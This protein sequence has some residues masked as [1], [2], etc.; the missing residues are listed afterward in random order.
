M[1]PLPTTVTWQNNAQCEETRKK[2]ILR[3][4]NV[5]Q[6]SISMST[7]LQANSNSVLPQNMGLNS[8]GIKHPKSSNVQNKK[9]KRNKLSIKKQNRDPAALWGTEGRAGLNKIPR[10]EIAQMLAF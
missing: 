3:G 9:E 5:I 2:Q 6:K 4:G 10:D 8:S 1:V 7:V